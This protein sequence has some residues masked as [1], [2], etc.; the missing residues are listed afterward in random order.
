MRL[1]AVVTDV[2]NAGTLTDYTGSL[3]AEVGLR[4]TD[5]DNTPHPGGPG[6]ATVSDASFAFAGAVRGDGR[7]DD[8]QHLLGGHLGRR[9]RSGQREGAAACHLAAR[10]RRGT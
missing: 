6:A 3:S 5:K 9:R 1:E 2:R 10:S 8:R 7:Y 4:V